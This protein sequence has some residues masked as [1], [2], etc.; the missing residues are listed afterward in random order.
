MRRSMSFCYMLRHKLA[1]LLQ[2]CQDLI[3]C[4]LHSVPIVSGAVVAVI[5]L[6]IVK[7]RNNNACLL[8]SSFSSFKGHSPDWNLC[9]RMLPC[10]TRQVMSVC[11][12][13]GL[14]HPCHL[15]GWYSRQGF[16]WVIVLSVNKDKGES[17]SVLGMQLNNDIVVKHHVSN[18]KWGLTWKQTQAFLPLGYQQV[19][20]SAL[21]SLSVKFGDH[22]GCISPLCES[23]LCAYP[24][25]RL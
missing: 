14:Q 24:A 8:C 17:A 7:Q 16:L 21:T 18:Q 13:N 23:G 9:V 5:V 20:M 3:I 11:T 6:L 25:F 4:W 22:R 1:C 12:N 15:T 19:L 2:S 10:I